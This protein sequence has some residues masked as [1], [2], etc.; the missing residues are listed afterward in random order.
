MKVLSYAGMLMSEKTSFAKTLPK[1]SSQR[2][3]LA[4]QFGFAGGFKKLFLGVQR[5]AAFGKSLNVGSNHLGT[6]RIILSG[7]GV[8]VHSGSA[9]EAY[10]CDVGFFG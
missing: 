10:E 6:Y 3:S 5:V 7:T 4:L 1:A 2:N 9:H 8:N